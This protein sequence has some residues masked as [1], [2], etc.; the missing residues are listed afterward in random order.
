MRDLK[1]TKYGS[2][3]PVFQIDDAAKSTQGGFNLD[4]TGLTAGAIVPQGA[5]FGFDEATRVA[6]ILKGA[7]LVEALGA[8]GK[9]VKVAKGHLF[10]KDDF[11]MANG[12]ST[13]ITA[14]NTSNANY[15]TLTT[16]A[17]LTATP[18]GAALVAGKAEAGSNGVLAVEP[19]GLLYNEVKVGTDLDV[20]ILERG[21]VYARRIPAVTDEVKAK[22]PNIIFSQSY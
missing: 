21:T 8:T 6:K 1:R 18:E 16:T 2:G 10:A 17:D 11:I 9:S 4:T 14:I 19:K 5:V 13:K 12:I 3:I 20:T 7:T 22:L 15:D